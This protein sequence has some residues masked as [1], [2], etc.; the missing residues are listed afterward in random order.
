M[1]L[2][3][4]VAFLLSGTA[5]SAN[6]SPCTPHTIDVVSDTTNTVVGNGNA[7]AATPHVA[8]TASIPGATWIW[9]SPPTTPNEV[10]GFEKSFTVV[11]TVLSA[12]LDI[13]TDNSYKVFIDNVEV[14]ADANA[15]NFTLAEQDSI[16]LTASIAAGAHTLRIEVKNHG[17]FNASSN[18]AGLLYK[19]V[20]NSEDCCPSS[21]DCCPG[22]ITIT[23]TNNAT[24]VNNVTTVANTGGNS[25]SGGNATNRVRGW[26]NDN[27]SSSGGDGGTVITGNASAGASVVNKINKNIV[28]IRR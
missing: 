6:G 9:E 11:G 12:Q 10:V 3:A 21:P 22:D 17:T 25:S 5:V 27:N 8:W 20:V 15:I 16:N 14:A 23:N 28:R 2:V 4:T 13:A 7:V 18:P 24:V 26:N 19:L 1:A